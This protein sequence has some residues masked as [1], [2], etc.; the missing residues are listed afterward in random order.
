MCTNCFL[1]VKN[2]TALTLACTHHRETIY[3]TPKAVQEGCR[4]R[5]Y[6]TLLAPYVNSKLLSKVVLEI[7]REAESVFNI[8]GNEKV[9]TYHRSF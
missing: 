6:N 2:A 8:Y 3:C 7:T 1:P 4:L 5:T 9:K